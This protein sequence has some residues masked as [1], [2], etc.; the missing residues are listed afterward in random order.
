MHVESQVNEALRRLAQAVENENVAMLT[1]HEGA[2]LASRPMTPLRMDADGAFWFM[3]SRV[4]LAPFIDARESD[5]TAVNLAFCASGD[6]RY[7]SVSGRARLVEDARRKQELWTPMARAWFQGPEDADLSLLRVEPLQAEVWQGPGS[8][9]T[10]LLA[11]AA[12]TI[13]GREIGLGEKHT[14]VP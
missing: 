10:R 4:A 2:V 1:L 12:S 5:G 8:A 14:L 7:V 13:A 3:T 11:Q 9:V 6:G